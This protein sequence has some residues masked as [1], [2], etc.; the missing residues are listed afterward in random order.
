MSRV[1]LITFFFLIERF[2]MQIYEHACKL[3]TCAVW[4]SAEHVQLRSAVR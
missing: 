4:G 1:S 2:I 3:P